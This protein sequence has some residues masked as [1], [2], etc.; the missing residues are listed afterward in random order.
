MSDFTLMGIYATPL[1]ACD[2]VGVQYKEI[3]TRAGFSYLNLEHGGKGDGRLMRF[4][5]GRGGDLKRTSQNS[6]NITR[7]RLK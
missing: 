2:A 5:D 3:G 4:N 6:N 1:E 7:Y